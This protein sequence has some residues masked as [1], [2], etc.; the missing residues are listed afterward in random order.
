MVIH[1][2]ESQQHWADQRVAQEQKKQRKAVRT[3]HWS[4]LGV[5]SL[6]CVAILLLVFVLKLAG[7]GAYNRLKQS[8]REALS[9]NQL[10]TVLSGLW[11]TE[12]PSAEEEEFSV[13]E[14]A[15]TEEKTRQNQGVIAMEGAQ[16]RLRWRGA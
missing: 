6:A 1:N 15:L 13:K 3:G 12:P 5:Q 9:K 8:F 14:S 2:R 11:E 4:V 10:M 7:G 16:L